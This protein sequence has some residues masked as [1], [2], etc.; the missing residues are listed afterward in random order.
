MKNEEIKV[1]VIVLTFNHEK[2]IAQALDSILMQKVDFNYEILVGDDASSDE[3]ANI[4]RQYAARHADKIYAH[5]RLRNIGAACN[6]YSLI[7]KARGEYLAFCE[8]DDFWLTED[9]LSQQVCFL[10]SNPAFIGCSHRCRVVDG[11]GI[12]LKKQKISWVREKTRFS[13][14]D[15][16]GVYLPGQTA[17]I[18]KRNIFK[19]GEKDCS[20]LYQINRNISDRTST[21]LYLTKGDFGLIPQV[22]SAYRRADGGF[23]SLTDTLYTHNPNSLRFELD[24]TEK[25]DELA[26]TRWKLEN[27]FRPY[28]KQLYA[29]A[30]YH[31]FKNPCANGYELVARTA[32][33]IGCGIIHPLAFG[34]GACQK[35]WNLI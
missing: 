29:S 1:S 26:K 32:A 14:S 31:F 19:N 4:V 21:L 22:M 12:A 2:Y 3:T 7:Q 11:D 35:I 27:I 20:F 34:Y 23:Q 6:A 30:V 17:T 28:Y 9:K 25:L 24:F 13:L 10:D 8:G 33:H 16:K 18:M 5:F 15:F